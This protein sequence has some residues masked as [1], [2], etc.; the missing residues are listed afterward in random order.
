[1]SAIVKDVGPAPTTFHL[2]KATLANPDYRQVAW[3]GKYLQVT[4]MSIDQGE[5]IGLEVHPETDQLIRI[6]QGTG[7]ATLGPAKD[8]LTDTEVGPGDVV[9]V[10][11][12]TWHNVVNTGDTTLK[13][14]TV[15]APV[16]HA[17]GILQHTAAQ[18]EADEKDGKDVPPKFTVQP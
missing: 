14:Y 15:Y 4:L 17:Q 8:K 1:V 7:V 2:E 5:S 11:A 9:L 13:V 16:H 3:T 6:E 18:A 12:G 10:T